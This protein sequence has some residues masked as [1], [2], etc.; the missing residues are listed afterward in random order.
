LFQEII[1]NIIQHAQ[2]SEISITLDQIDNLYRIIIQD[3]GIG[4]DVDE[5]LKN[6]TGMG[7]QNITKRIAM[8]KGTASISSVKGSGSV[9]ILN[10]PYI[11]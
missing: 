10:I 11:D 5:V 7:M 4:F 9:I 6:K 3:N 1:N 8:I 2:A